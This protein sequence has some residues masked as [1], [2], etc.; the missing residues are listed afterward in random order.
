MKFP[1]PLLRGSLV[2]R[3]RRSL[4]D[5]T[6]DD[7]TM[8]TAH[9]A[10]PGPMVGC[11]TPGNEVI[12]SDSGNPGRRHRLTWELIRMD[13]TWVCINPTI[14][15]KVVF[16]ALERRLIPS[17]QQYKEIERETVYGSDMKIDMILQGMERNCFLN[18]F[19]VTW[20]ENGTASFPDVAHQR[21][22]KS[23]TDLAGIA[24]QGH[25]AVAFFFV[26]RG[27]CTL[28]KPAEHVDR[29]FL[30]AL[31]HAEDKGVEILVYRAS[32]TLEEIGLGV[33][34]VYSLQ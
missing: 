13:E 28:F 27:D 32:I 3:Y 5:V 30:K 6:L 1:T 2:K 14:A 23:V 9:C 31:L 15:R 19:N 29:D 22:R 10:N 21:Y 17:L 4:V 12:L 26:Q 34:L 33:P 8:V 7:G 16:D 25:S 20:V 24:A 18:I 11:C